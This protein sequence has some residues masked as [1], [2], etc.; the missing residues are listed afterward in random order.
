VKN[1]LAFAG[2]LF[3]LQFVSPALADGERFEVSRIAPLPQR[4][5]IGDPRPHMLPDGEVILGERDI[6]AAW[7]TGPTRRYSHGVLGDAIEASGLAVELA[8]GRHLSLELGPGSVFEDRFPRLADLNGDG[9]DEI[10]LVR[11]Y[12]DA[13][14]A[15][16]IAGIEDDRLTIIAES[17]PIGLPNRWLNPVGAADF[18]GDGRTEIAVVRTP[19]IGGILMLYRWEKGKLVEAYRAH[20]FSNH[21][22]GS[23]EL[24]LSAILDANGDGVPD[25]VLPDATRRALRIVTFAGGRFE[26]VA[27]FLHQ[28][29]IASVKEIKGKRGIVYALA[30]GSTWQVSPKN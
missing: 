11:S 26:D 16:A 20:G 28:S 14:A 2:I 4:A 27:N 15:V 5:F 13:G 29:P 9:S 23:R 19:H 18:D 30:D 3:F 24:G 8:N 10:I 17:D 1:R 6:A 25:I 12:L 7:L 22:M 21:A